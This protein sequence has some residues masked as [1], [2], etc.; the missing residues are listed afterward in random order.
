MRLPVALVFCSILL[1]AGCKKSKSLQK[2]SPVVV[3]GATAVAPS[4]LPSA[5]APLRPAQTR[6][7]RLLHTRLDLLPRWDR[8]ELEGTAILCLTPWFRPQD[9]LVLDAKGMH[10]H[11]LALLLPTGPSPLSYRYDADSLRLHIALGSLFTRTDTLELQ[12]RYTA[13]PYALRLPGSESIADARGLYFIN[14]DGR[15]PLKPTQLWTQ[16]QP[17]SASC[18]FPTLDD[19]AQRSTQEVRLTVPDSMLT[20]SNGR[21]LGGVPAGEGLRTDTWRMDLPHPPYLFMIAAGKFAR[22]QDTWRDVPVDYYVEPAFEPYARLVFGHTPEMIEFFSTLF[23]FPYPWPKYSQIVV[24]DFVSGAMENTTATVHNGNLQ[25]D[26]RQH[27]DDTEEDYISHE[28]FHQWFGNVVTCES[29]GQLSLNEGLTTYGE[30]LWR[31]YK[32]GK[33][34]ADVQ[35][36]ESLRGYLAEAEGKREPVIRTRHNSPGDMFDSHSYSKGGCVLHQLRQ[37]MGD[38]AFFAGL[39][40]YLHRHAFQSVEV[41]QLR[42]AFEDVLGED[43]NWFF[44]QWLLQRGHPEL[45]AAYRYDWNA[46]QLVINVKQTQDL[47]YQPL[48]R[49]Q[50]LAQVDG[51]LGTQFFPLELTRQDTT[52]RLPYPRPEKAS[53]GEEDLPSFIYNADLDSRHTLLGTLKDEKPSRCWVYQLTNGRNFSQTLDALEQVALLAPGPKAAQA[54]WQVQRHPGWHLRNMALEALGDFYGPDNRQAWQDSLET[55]YRRDPQPAVRATALRLLADLGA[56]GDELLPEDRLEPLRKVLRMGMQDSSYQVVAQALMALSTLDS[57]QVMTYTLPVAD[58][59]SEIIQ[60]TVTDIL[61]ERK[62]PM[63]NDYVVKCLWRM[64]GYGRMFIIN[65]YVAYAEDRNDAEIEAVLPVLKYTAQ[66]DPL[67]FMRYTAARALS[68][69]RTRRPELAGWL[70]QLKARETDPKLR[71]LLDTF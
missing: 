25:H 67:W 10:I 4:W 69:L 11:E 37:Y 46:G 61:L 19:P 9:T 65:S 43:L 50:F 39:R 3:P 51:H 13:R 38:D 27:L 48:Y 8:R 34:Y 66:E 44:D 15:H 55:I 56:V 41:H 54:L 64:P 32:Y 42:I 31:E 17:E 30:Y 57:A 28:L 1:V 6:Y 63:V 58:Y 22:V 18:W 60:Q 62:H 29:W 14:P 26:A 36:E 68:E 52:F 24:R 20:L 23:D 49:L 16:G 40:L 2:H 21:F 45:T 71:N 33:D 47:R 70:K 59:P 35:F 5:E 7:F 12:V 53:G